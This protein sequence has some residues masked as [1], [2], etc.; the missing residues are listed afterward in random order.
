[1]VVRVAGL[2]RSF[3][4]VAAYCLH[5]APEP[6]NRQPETSERVEWTETRGLPTDRPERA[7][8]IMAATARDAVELKRLAGGSAVGRPLQKPVYHYSLNWAPDEQPT[9]AEML[10]A[11]DGSLEALGLEGR[12][13]LI[14]AHTDRAHRHC[15]VIVNRVDPWDG[16]AA[17]LGRDR[18]TLSRWAEGWEIEQGRIR[19][20]RRAGNNL[21][22]GA[23]AWVEDRTSLPTG[24]YRR[25]WMSPSR[26]KVEAVPAGR[27]PQERW[28]VSWQRAEA[29]ARWE[30]LQG[31]RARKLRALDLQ[32]RREWAE[33]M[34]RQEQEREQLASDSRAGGVR[35]VLGRLRHWR[36]RGRLRELGAV[37]G[38]NRE[39]LRRWRQGLEREH[40]RERA[41]LGRRHHAETSAI[42]AEL[43]KDYHASLEGAEQRAKAAVLG[44]WSAIRYYP[45][46]NPGHLRQ[47]VDEAELDQ[48]REVDG[49]DAYQRITQRLEAHRRR[50]TKRDRA[51]LSR[52]VRGPDRGPERGGGIER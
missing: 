52:P 50:R 31:R 3:R 13:A 2:G 46:L 48:V 19:C 38:A 17:K 7:A 42:E 14:V 20:H 51:R 4:G 6:E 24:R 18:I 5:D 43:A 45:G 39:L 33:L 40:R 22:R 30:K 27:D 25:E 49:E 35:G 28:V 12:Q 15:H 9:K 21:R 32:R 29:K 47:L 26:A 37:I 44:G 23:G 16:K 36:Q 1:M 8:A 11:V 41:V 10:R 34:V